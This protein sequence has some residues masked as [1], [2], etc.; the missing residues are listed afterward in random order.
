MRK[1]QTALEYLMTYGWAILIIV[2]VGAA[3]YALGVFSP[4]TFAAGKA[5]L[6]FSILS[7]QDHLFK[8]DGIVSVEL[9][10]PKDDISATAILLTDKDD[11]VLLNETLTTPV[12]IEA[13][14]KA[15]VTTTGVLSQTG[16]E[17][18]SQVKLTITYDVVGGISGHTDTA[19][20]NGKWE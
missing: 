1:G 13:N 17:A 18:Y 7:Y 14:K 8:G 12:T 11:V 3:L 16:G 15:T 2:I 5:C 10:S 4:G 20:C 9:G 19:T 6:G